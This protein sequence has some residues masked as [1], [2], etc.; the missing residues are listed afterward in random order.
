MLQLPLTIFEPIST[1]TPPRSL[2]D[3]SSA[4]EI[5]IDTE[6]RDPGLKTKGPGFIRNDGHV[7]GIS[8][9]ADTGFRGYFPIGHE[10]GGNLDK[11]LVSDWLKQTCLRDR[12]YIFANAQYDLGW[13]ATL[14]IEVKGTINDICI[15]DTLID[16]ERSD[17]Y[18]LEALGLRWLGQG[19]DESMLKE[20]IIA[21]SLTNPKADL[22]KLPARFAG[23][24]AETDAIRTFEVFQKQKKV[25]RSENLWEVYKMERTL[26]PVLFEMFRRG[27]RV[28]GSYAEAL[29]DDW[30]EREREL[31]GQLGVTEQDLWS[32]S[33]ISALCS[34]HD[35][36][37]PRTE[38]GNI[39]LTKD[40][41]TGINHPEINPFIELR[42]IQRTRSVYLE[43][44]LI[45]N[46]VNGRIHP[47]YIQMASDDGGTRTMRL[48]A[49]NPNAQQFPKRSR[50]FDAKAIRTCLIPEE[51]CRWAKADYWSQEPVVQLHYALLKKLPGAEEVKA[52]FLQGTKLAS[53][54]EKA[55]KGR[56]NYDQAKEVTLGRSYG[57]GPSKMSSR[58]GISTRECSELLEAFDNV[59][60]YVSMLAKSVAS[61]A[62]TRG[63]IK[64]LAGHKRH[65]NLFEPTRNWDKKYESDRD[66]NRRF[67]AMP[68]DQAQEYYRVNGRPVLLQRAF[69]Y[70]AF[71]SLIQGG[72]AG[73]TKTALLGVAQAVAL[74]QIQVHD[75]L[76]VSVET[77][78]QGKQ[79]EEIMVNCIPLLSPVRV[80]LDIGNSWQ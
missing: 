31:M 54:I 69:V 67:P 28:D 79:I 1:W 6:N 19:K 26:T 46:V 77:D 27:I 24:Y 45:R 42:A 43:Q 29:N 64:T 72:S 32:S 25:L 30:K 4:R 13:L 60:P 47:Q 35:I 41:L 63:Y 55:T 2:P 71:N 11:S 76:G 18:S 52:Q 70:K 59:V 17:G 40:Y 37:I 49:R 80:D 62:V 74:P 51:G 8:I 50:L 33:F 53:F 65:F 5:A 68:W 16:E 10:G 21:Y 56:L 75:E 7:A 58:M 34:K 44:N 36:Y 23:T 38:K 66:D 14:G 12:D 15:A 48:A 22:W 3:L 57:M 78:K 73:Q 61:V 9:C 20:A 39:S